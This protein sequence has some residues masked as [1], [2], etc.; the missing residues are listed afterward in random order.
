[1]KIKK[2]KTNEFDSGVFAN[3]LII[4]IS[5][6]ELLW[7]RTEFKNFSFAKCHTKEITEPKKALTCF[8][9]GLVMSSN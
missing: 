8:T 4:Q 6:L 7:Q 9:G 3:L 2:F 1:M 5:Y